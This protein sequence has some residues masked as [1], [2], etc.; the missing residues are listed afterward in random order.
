MIQGSSLTVIRGKHVPCNRA[1][2]A[3]DAKQSKQKIHK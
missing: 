1:R 3:D 2:R